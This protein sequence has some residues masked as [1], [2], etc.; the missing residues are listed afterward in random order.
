MKFSQ[1]YLKPS[2]SAKAYD[3]LNATLLTKGGFIRQVMAGVYTFLPLGLRVLTKIETIVRRHMDTVATEIMM[4]ALSPMSFWRQTGRFETIDVLIKTQGANALSAR[5]NTDQYILNCTHE[6]NITAMMQTEALS[7]KDFP[8]AL[9]Q[10]QSKFR[11]EAR[12]KSGLLRG[13]EFRMKDL[14]SFH[15]S[16]EEF[17]QYYEKI[18]QVYIDI[19]RDLGL[20]AQTVVTLASG[21]DFTKDFSHEFQTRC[22]TGE[23][24]IFHAVKSDVYYNREVT[25]VRAPSVPQE[26]EQKTKEKIHTP[27]ARTMDQLVPMLNVKKEQCVKTILYQTETK[28]LVAAAVRGDR[29]VSENKLEKVLD[30]KVTLAKPEQITA[31][32]GA[33]V[34]YA[35]IVDLPDSVKL[36][37]DDSLA[38]LINFESGA[39]QTDYHWTNL[40]WDRDIPKPTQFFEIK[41]A[42]EGDLDPETDQPYPTFRASEVGNIFPLGTKYPD[43]FNYRFTDEQGLQQPIY[44]GSYGIGTSRVMGVIA[45]ISNDERGLIWPKAIAPFQVHLVSLGDVSDKAATTYQKMSDLGVEIIWDDRDTSAG[46]KLADADLIGCPIRLVISAKTGGQLEWKPRTSS[47]TELLSLDQVIKRLTDAKTAANN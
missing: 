14:Y 25:P 3:S 30:C 43:A 22:E 12:A 1:L 33:E 44:M 4:S 31:V 21:G 9:Y 6:D 36:I 39:N 20:G 32:T 38:D 28:E 35:G 19:F 37:C 8:I 29:E 13:R 10:I 45:E 16:L 34:G 11:N 27:G 26:A 46:V 18:K 42:H 15:R 5:K 23:D 40:N 41:L 47:A 24:I 2:K 17:N 7:Y